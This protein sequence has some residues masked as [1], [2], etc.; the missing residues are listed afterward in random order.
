MLKEKQKNETALQC[1][2]DNV[3]ID[4]VDCAAILITWIGPPFWLRW[5]RRHLD[6]ENSAAAFDH[7]HHDAILIYENRAA[8]WPCKPYRHFN[9]ENRAAILTT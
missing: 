9:Y 4:H 6:Y 3:H 8:I 5:P 1:H 2:F 7:V